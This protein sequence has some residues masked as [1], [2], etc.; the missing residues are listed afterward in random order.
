ME[1]ASIVERRWFNHLFTELSVASGQIVPRYELWLRIGD[2]GV[3]PARLERGDV[4]SFCDEHLPAFLS[5]HQLAMSKRSH[6]KLLQS[7]RS[8]DPAQLSPEEHM[9]R[10]IAPHG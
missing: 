5:E 10:M 3:D 6:R 1:V 4:F 9:A 8:F 2:L 7:L